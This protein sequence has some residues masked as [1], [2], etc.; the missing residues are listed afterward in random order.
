MSEPRS[1]IFNEV[2]A[3][4]QHKADKQRPADVVFEWRPDDMGATATDWM[5]ANPVLGFKLDSWQQYFL[6]QMFDN[7]VDFTSRLNAAIAG[8]IWRGPVGEP[9]P[10]TPRRKPH[11][12]RQRGTDWVI[13]DEMVHVLDQPSK[14]DEAR[15]RLIDKISE[16]VEVKIV[17][18]QCPRFPRAE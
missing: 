6:E 17:R 3:E 7:P 13:L 2:A 14:I 4:L 18:I 1:W 12:R 9:P 15:Q 11:R 10:V 16:D 5:T 8:Q